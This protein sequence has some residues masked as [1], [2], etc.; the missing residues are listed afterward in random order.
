M[1]DKRKYKVST[2]PKLNAGAKA[3]TDE[4]EPPRFRDNNR[5][6]PLRRDVDEAS[7]SQDFREDEIDDRLSPPSNGSI[8]LPAAMP[9]IRN[10]QQHTQPG[11][12]MSP[13]QF[14]QE[15]LAASLTDADLLDH[16]K[17]NFF[18]PMR[19][20]LKDHLPYLHEARERFGQ[21]GR[22]VPVPGNPTLD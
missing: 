1:T 5:L 13:C 22:R 14:R 15:N 2:T 21:R 8:F 9:E 16:I 7:S 17:I 20:R 12:I 10:V 6:D 11:V 3:I 18:S 19:R 4:H